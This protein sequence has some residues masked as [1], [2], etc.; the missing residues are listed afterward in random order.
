MTILYA[1]EYNESPDNNRL[2]RKFKTGDYDAIYQMAMDMK[3]LINASMVLIPVPNRFG[4]P[5]ATKVLCNVLK[6]YTGCAVMDIL[7]GKERQSVY[8]A[9]KQ[10]KS[11]NSE[12][13]GFFINGNIPE[14]AYLVDNVIS[15]G[16]TMKYILR[17]IPEANI[18]VHSIDMGRMA[19]L[20]ENF[21]GAQSISIQKGSK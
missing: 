11:L 16:S 15:T 21:N 14:N 18:I 7:R 8:E 4:Y 19:D 17:L 6:A 20:G 13:F 10:L 5:D 2:V 1:K 12:D 3:S 9:K